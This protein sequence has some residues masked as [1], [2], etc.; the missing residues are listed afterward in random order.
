MN[1]RLIGLFG[2]RD[3]AI[4]NQILDVTAKLPTIVGVMTSHLVVM[5]VL[6]G[7]KVLWDRIW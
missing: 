5:T 3:L 6:V 2:V 1:V 7:L 4:V